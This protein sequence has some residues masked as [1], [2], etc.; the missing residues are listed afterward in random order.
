MPLKPSIAPSTLAGNARHSAMSEAPKRTATASF[1]APRKRMEPLVRAP[2]RYW[3]ARPPAP[4]HIGIAPNHAPTRFISPTETA[5]FLG[6]AGRSGKR[7]TESAQTATTELS[8]VSGI[9]GSAAFGKAVTK[10]GHVGGDQE[11]RKSP[12]WRERATS[13]AR[14]KARAS[15]AAKRTRA[16]GIRREENSARITRAAAAPVT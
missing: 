12:R 7:S 5:T 6:D 15:P 11:G 4:W 8:V 14:Q 3:P 1:A 10:A 13:G 9:C 2:N 16:D